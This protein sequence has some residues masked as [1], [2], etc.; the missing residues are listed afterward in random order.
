MTDWLLHNGW[1]AA[2]LA[3]ALGQFGCVSGTHSVSLSLGDRKSEEEIVAISEPGLLK[4]EVAAEG[5]EWKIHLVCWNVH[6]STDAMFQRELKSLVSDVGVDEGLIFCL[7]EARPA[8]WE[9]IRRLSPDDSLFGH[10]AESW[11]YPMAK[12]STGV[13]TINGPGVPA[14]ESERLQSRAREFFLTSP[15]VSLV[16]GL[17]LP[18]GQLL[19]VVNCHGLNFVTEKTFRAQLDQVFA[20]LEEGSNSGPAI[21]CGDF[22]VWSPG[23]LA[24][25][26]ARVQASGLTEASADG[27]S[28]PDTPA[29][30]RALT[31]LVGYDPGIPLD[32]IYTRGL[33]VLGCRTVKGLESS[34]HA[35]LILEFAAGA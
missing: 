15:K 20:S 9:A 16:S 5:D 31:P 11:R 14:V 1:R 4:E 33:K 26:E 19:R 13:M 6:K 28:G 10:Y 27:H 3:L 32:R 25:L 7:Q 35:P 34:D 23:R 24:A 29:F 8:T 2:F 17:V 21:V 22:N 12:T 18:D 30:L